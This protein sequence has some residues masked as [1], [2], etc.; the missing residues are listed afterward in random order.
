MNTNPKNEQAAG[1]CETPAAHTALHATCM[2]S[3]LDPLL[4][5]AEAARLLGMHRSTIWRLVKANRLCQPIRITARKVGWRRS[6]L[7]QFLTDCTPGGA[8]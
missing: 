8:E 5:P 7:E 4:P 2:S 6:V 3:Q 1:V